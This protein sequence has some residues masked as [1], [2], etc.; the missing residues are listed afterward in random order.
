MNIVITGAS[1]GIGFHT[2]VQLAN[3]SKNKI[4]ALSRDEVGLNKLSAVIG[5][6]DSITILPCDITNERSLERAI[7]EISKEVSGIEVLINNAGLLINKAF[8]M[9][10]R[11]DWQSVYDVNIFGVVNIT[12]SL[13][14]ML[15]NRQVKVSEL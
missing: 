7:E 4:F 8:S 14:P 15:M 6:P 10:T 3:N 9:L 12:R 1:K 5:L 13:L 11:A 2:A